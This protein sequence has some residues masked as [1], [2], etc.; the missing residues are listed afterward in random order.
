MKHS[1][2]LAGACILA[3]SLHHPATAQTPDTPIM[4][5]AVAQKLGLKTT[6]DA[7]RELELGR[8]ATGMLADPQKLTPV[9]VKGFH[10]GARVT[11]TCVGPARMRLEVEEMDAVDAGAVIREIV[12]LHV[13]DDGTITK[14]PDRPSQKPPTN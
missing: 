13:S 8:S 14:V 6:P 3:V 5:T 9:L 1:L 11:I 7:P 4:L 10:E 2:V 12:T